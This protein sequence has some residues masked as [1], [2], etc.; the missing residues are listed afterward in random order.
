MSSDINMI[1]QITM[2]FHHVIF[3]PEKIIAVSV[4]WNLDR[5]YNG[6][7]SSDIWL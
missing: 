5:K 7:R 1:L 3:D 4:R 6:D 2:I